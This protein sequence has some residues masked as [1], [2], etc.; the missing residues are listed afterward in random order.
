MRSAVFFVCLLLALG[1]GATPA[2]AMDCKDPPDQMTMNLCAAGDAKAARDELDALYGALLARLAEPSDRDLLTKSQ[3]DWEAYS[4]SE[5]AF[6]TSGSTGGS[7]HRMVVSLCLTRAA[8]ERIKTLTDVRD[9]GESDM[10]CWHAL[11]D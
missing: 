3:T 6:E 7:I 2:S 10:G 11:K 4:R 1:A 8:R 5:C 9:C